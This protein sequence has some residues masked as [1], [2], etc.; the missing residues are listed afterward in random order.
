MKC[1]MILAVAISFATGCAVLLSF[2]DYANGTGGAGAAAR[3]AT[4]RRRADELVVD[5]TVDA[6]DGQV[7]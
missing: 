2:S 6:R 1:V 5:G 7:R 3:G 4:P